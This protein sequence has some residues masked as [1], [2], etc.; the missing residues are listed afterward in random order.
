MIILIIEAK[1]VAK[2]SLT[3]NIDR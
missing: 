2:I 1:A 3:D